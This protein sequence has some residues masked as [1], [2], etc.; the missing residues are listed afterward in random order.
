MSQ[1]IYLLGDL[2]LSAFQPWSLPTGDAFLEWFE[3]FDPEPNS[4]FIALGDLMNDAVNPGAVIRQLERFINIAQSKF[5]HTYLLVG[6]H[7]LKLYKNAPQLSFDYA[8]EKPNVTILEEPAEVL[9]IANLSVLSLPHYNYRHDLPAMS[10][11][12]EN[13][14]EDIVKQSYDLILG[15]FADTSAFTFAHNIDLTYLKTQLTCLGD[16]HSRISE[17]YIG[18]VYACKISENDTPRPRALWRVWKESEIVRKE[19][20]NLPNFC[21]YRVVT[22]PDPLPPQESPVEVWTVLGAENEVIAKQFYKNAFIRGVHLSRKRK[23]KRTAS[24]SEDFIMREPVEVF[25]EWLREV[26]EPISRPVAK[27][28]RD[29]LKPKSDPGAIENTD[30]E[31][32]FEFAAE[33][34]ETD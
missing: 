12:Y 32:N 25:G 24:S 21:N 9:Q 8:R 1:S 6:N 15:H 28:I 7:D 16:I 26:R 17:N 34:I 2:H 13:L 11:Y 29:L 23:D 33:T 30:T 5:S 14:P 22:Y 10:E 31:E 3:A 18:S 19:E 20:I 4:S 27:L